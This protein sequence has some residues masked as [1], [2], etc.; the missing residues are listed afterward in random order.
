MAEQV[1]HAR[2][3]FLGA[4]ASTLTAASLGMGGAV[5][6]KAVLDVAPTSS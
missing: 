3:L 1:K 4:A 2:R 6:R 5:A